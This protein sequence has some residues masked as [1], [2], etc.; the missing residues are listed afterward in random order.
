MEKTRAEMRLQWAK[1][2]R[3]WEDE[4]KVSQIRHS[5]LVEEGAFKLT[6]LPVS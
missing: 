2:R 1:L 4:L 6:V 3:M 5:G